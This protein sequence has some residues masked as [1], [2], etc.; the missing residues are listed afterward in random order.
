LIEEVMKKKFETSDIEQYFQVTNTIAP[1]ISEEK[2]HQIINSP[3]AKARL[4]GKPRNF[5]KFTLMTTLFAVIISAILFW[6]G[7]EEKS[8]IPNNTVQTIEKRPVLEEKVH[9]NYSKDNSFKF[10]EQQKNAESNNKKSIKDGSISDDDKNSDVAP[11]ISN[12]LKTSNYALYKKLKNDSCDFEMILFD[13]KEWDINDKNQ[14]IWLSIKSN[15][16]KGLVSGEYHFSALNKNVCK[17]M[18]F[19]GQYFFNPDSSIKIT[20]GKMT[21]DTSKANYSIAYEFIMENNQKISG[22]YL[23]LPVEKEILNSTVDKPKEEFVYPEQILDSTTFIELNRKELEN[24]GFKLKDETIELK[25][26]LNGGNFFTTYVDSRMVFGVTFCDDPNPSKRKDNTTILAENINISMFSKDALQLSGG[27]VPMLITVENGRRLV[28][29]SVTENDLKALFS[30]RFTKDFKTL[31]PVIMRKNTFACYPKEDVVYWFIPTD[32]FFNRLPQNISKELLVEY[33]Y[34]TAEDK[35]T[36]EKPE[37]KYFDE[38]KNTLKI[39]SFMVYPNPASANATVS[40]TLP[41]AITGRITLVDLSGRERQVLKPQTN[42]AK[43][44]HSIEV[45]VS[46]VPEGIYL[47]TLYS[48]KGIQ[49]QRLIV[50]K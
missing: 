9:Q 50:N 44:S 23:P 32:E 42:Y 11:N 45:D 39:S 33:D 37:C 5:L 36:L 21:V 18:S 24:L 16:T 35:S 15:Q 4:K 31:L 1:I 20:D 13:K 19:S 12:I 34:I 29:Q 2:V 30:K 14:T 8:Q 3:A 28:K 48:N 46:S 47:I 22:K 40:F 6:P 17:P 25:Y 49:T 38:C 26:L 10:N 7:D 41:E 27:I 43:G